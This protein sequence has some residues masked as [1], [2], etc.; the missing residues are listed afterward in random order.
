MPET[1]FT[2]GLGQDRIYRLLNNLNLK[3]GMGILGVFTGFD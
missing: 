3:L 2:L 1:K